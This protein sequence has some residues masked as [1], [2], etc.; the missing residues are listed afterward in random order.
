MCDFSEKLIAWL[1][2]ELTAN[3]NAKVEQH[4][5]SCAECRQNLDGYQRVS[6]ALEAYCEVVFAS[7]SR[8]R[9][10]RWGPVVSAI[11]A[12]A[13]ALFLAYPHGRIDQ[14]SVHISPTV[15]SAG[16]TLEGGSENPIKRVHRRR[17]GARKQIQNA[18]WTEA[19][20]SIQIA[21]PAEAM[22]P[23]GAVPEGVNFVADMSISADGS[24][25]QLRLQPRL[26]G[27]ERR[28]QP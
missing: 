19:R 1:D 8:P 27:F 25:Q 23:P 11:V 21:I 28:S 9:L 14:P 7:K 17:A 4:V 12:T 5:L 15:T 2:Q 10:P 20:P 6:T 16:A 13:V 24:A 3:E 22:F 26:I 18:S